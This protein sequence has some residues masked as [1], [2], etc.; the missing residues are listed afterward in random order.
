[1]LKCKTHFDFQFQQSS[2]SD[3]YRTSPTSEES[4]PTVKQTT[5]IYSV[6]PRE[7]LPAT[8]IPETDDDTST[9]TYIS[10]SSP[11]ESSSTDGTTEHPSTVIGQTTEIV[12]FT[13][14]ANSPPQKQHRTKKVAVTA[15]KYFR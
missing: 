9:F 7:I 6:D 10:P 15:G 5:P 1:M 2:S 8:D 13:L 14:A 4:T 12:R 3:V 11:K